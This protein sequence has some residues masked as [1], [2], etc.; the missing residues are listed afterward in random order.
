[1]TNTLLN[2]LLVAW[3]LISFSF[4]L[5]TCLNI[6]ISFKIRHQV[7]LPILIFISILSLS[8]LNAYI[9]SISQTPITWLITLSENLTWAYG[10]L[11][12]FI[13]KQILLHEER[14]RNLFLHL[15]PFFIINTY[16]QLPSPLFKDQHWIFILLFIQ[17][18]TYAIYSAIRLNRYKSKLRVLVTGHRNTTYFW[19]LFL[20]GGLLIASTIDITAITLLTRSYIGSL[21]WITFIAAFLNTYICG[22]AL[23]SLYQPQVFPINESSEPIIQVVNI[24][25]SKELTPDLAKTIEKKLVQLIDESKPHLDPDI[26]LPKLATLLGVSRNQ[27]SELFNVYKATSFYSYLNDLRYQEA[28]ELLTDTRQKISIG[29]IAY[30]SGF[31]NR[32][33]FYKT[34]KQKTGITPIEYRKRSLHKVS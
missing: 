21:T 14:T 19:L 4:S 1:M 8:P 26:S 27:L 33:S 16:E 32:N 3:H 31:N 11:L 24:A 17:T 5:W 12:Y 2:E 23:L 18:S 7:K 13:V 15:L 30:Q 29:D 34:F 9:Q 28:L 6:A 20:A 10:P 22:I 25:K